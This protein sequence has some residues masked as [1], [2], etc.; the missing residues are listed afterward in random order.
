M[1]GPSQWQ[2]KP[3]CLATNHTLQIWLWVMLTPI[4][5]LPCSSRISDCGSSNLLM[6]SKEL[7]LS[8]THSWLLVQHSSLFQF[9]FQPHPV[10]LCL[11]CQNLTFSQLEQRQR[12]VCISEK[13]KPFCSLNAISDIR[14]DSP[15]IW[16]E[17]RRDRFW[18]LWSRMA[19]LWLFTVSKKWRLQ[20]QM[21]GYSSQAGC[22]L[23]WT[24]LKY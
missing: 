20:Y 23:W 2:M 13:W 5:A 12:N 18:L 17:E 8:P 10:L 3:G 16:R 7:D 11:G 9:Q 21:R 4:P 22:G 19:N 24:C 1:Q 14:F 6:T 15:G